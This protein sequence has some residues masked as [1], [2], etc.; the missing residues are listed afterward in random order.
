MNSLIVGLLLAGVAPKTG[1]GMPGDP[2]IGKGNKSVPTTINYQAYITHKSDT[3]PLDTTANFT[4]RIYDAPSGGNLLW[5]ENQ[6]DVPVIKGILDTRLGINNPLPPTI[7]YTGQT[8]WLE[9][10]M[11]TETFSPRKALVS[12]GQAFHAQKADTAEYAL[13]SPPVPDTVL[14]SWYSDTA[15]YSSEGYH[16]I[17]SDTADYA[18]NVPTIPDTV[19]FSW[20]SDTASW[21]LDGAHA[22]LADSATHADTSAYSQ[23]GY[24]VIYSDTANYARNVPGPGNY[25]QNQIASAQA[26]DF[27]IN[28]IGRAGST[29]GKRGELNSANYGVYGQYDANNYGYIGA[30]GH[31]VGGFSNSTGVFGSGNNY[32]VFGWGGIYGVYG[33]YDANNYGY[34]GSNQVGAFGTGTLYGVVGRYD[35]NNYGY[36]GGNGTGAYGTGTNTGVYGYVSTP[37][38]DTGVKGVAS[39]G[40]GAAD[41][42]VYG[43]GYHGVWGYGEYGVIGQASTIGVYGYAYTPDGDT[44]VKG[45]TD[46]SN[47]DV[48]VWGSGFYG[49]WGQSNNYC[50]VY[51][52][53]NWYGV[54]GYATHY[55]IVG[56]SNT[57]TA[58]YGYTT[59]ANDTVLLLE[60]TTPGDAEFRFMTDGNAYADG[61]WNS[62]GADFAEMVSVEG[63]RAGYEPGDVLVISDKPDVYMEKC[64]EPYSTKVAG[65]YST[66]PGF[67]AGSPEEGSDGVPMAVVGFVPCKVSG[68]GGAIKKGDL[69][70]TSS[71]PGYAMK[72]S[73]VDLGGVEIYRPGTILGK[74]MEDFSGD[75]GVILIY[76]NVK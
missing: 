29:S 5:T 67:T 47:N 6:S 35:A 7:F 74:A 41:I 60:G 31:G 32:G 11:G 66:Q 24:H 57:G 18:R 75:K 70:T 37:D 65:I 50:G 15:R 10:V 58:I 38:A 44:G 39:G 43:F 23:E 14:F 59:N 21:S 61:T 12:V 52:N 72:A 26:A 40:G 46:A 73:P 33:Q 2:A 53:G 64:S 20:Y 48:G 68:E 69:L 3:T 42:G 51:G 9:V 4:F 76:V 30:N 19:L 71:T 17:Y 54:F 1:F 62:G 34:L 16:V 55:G 63:E 22:H 28:G 49:V 36:L 27:W 13:N 56:Y 25:I 45:V 8:L